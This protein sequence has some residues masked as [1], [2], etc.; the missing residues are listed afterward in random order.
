MVAGLFYF[1]T[2]YVKNLNLLRWRGGFWMRPFAK[3]FWVPLGEV[4]EF[5]QDGLRASS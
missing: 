5:C 4:A 1:T 2:Q 3:Q